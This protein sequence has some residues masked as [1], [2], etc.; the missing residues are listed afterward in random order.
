MTLDEVVS[1][2]CAAWNEKDK[3]ARSALLN[4]CWGND[5]AIT[6]PLSF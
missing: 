3:A 2:Y 6:H 5:G 1:T 4:K